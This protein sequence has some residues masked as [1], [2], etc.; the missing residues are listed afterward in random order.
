M[1]AAAHCVA[2]RRSIARALAAVLL[3]PGGSAWAQPGDLPHAKVELAIAPSCA[4]VSPAEVRRIAAL[5]LHAETSDPP[6]HDEGTTRVE[7]ACEGQS[8]RIEVLDPLT[9]KTL[10][11]KIALARIATAARSR[12]LAL[13]VAELVSAS[14]IEL[15]TNPTPAAEPV[16]P[17]VRPEDRAAVREIVR[18]RIAPPPS[19]A[20]TAPAPLPAPAEGVAPV[21]WRLQGELG[22]R[23]MAVDS[24]PLLGLGGRI[25]LDPTHTV[26]LDLDLLGEHA[27]STVPLGTVALDAVSVGAVVRLRRDWGRLSV[28]GGPGA[29]VG[30]ARVSGSPVSTATAVGHEVDGLWGGPLG[31]V[32]LDYTMS[33]GL[34]LGVGLEAGDVVLPVRGVVEGGRDV[35]MDGFFAGATLCAGWAF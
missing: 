23:W 5:E 26:G 29:R 30:Y 7:L 34:S 2:V 19:P 12:L 10:A 24:S 9:G 16:A 11:R 32:G 3:I 17:V 8:A 13:A 18:E 33:G 25:T 4:D 28:H 20:V 31:S 6:V 15:E 1:P 27:T 21:R 35:R 14:W 22:A